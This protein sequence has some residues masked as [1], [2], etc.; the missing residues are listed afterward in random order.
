[1]QYVVMLTSQLCCEGLSGQDLGLLII[2]LSGVV[3][4]L[5]RSWAVIPPNQIIYNI[6]KICISKDSGHPCIIG[7]CEIQKLWKC[8]FVR[9]DYVSGHCTA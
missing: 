6:R 9:P 5:E 8:Q 2:I 1:M 3:S 4:V 7:W